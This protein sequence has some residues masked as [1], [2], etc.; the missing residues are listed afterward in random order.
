MPSLFGAGAYS[1]T[2]FGGSRY[3]AQLA[4][5]AEHKLH[6]YVSKLQEVELES[7]ATPAEFLA[8]RD[9]ARAITQVASA[10]TRGSPAAARSALAV[11]IQLDNAPLDGWLGDPGWNVVQAR[12]QANLTTLGIDPA[13][14]DRTLADMKSAA[15][16]A[17]V[18]Y[19]DYQSLIAA[20]DSYQDARD[21]VPNGYGSFPDPQT[22]YTQH[23]R[24]FFRGL[25]AGR[26]DAVAKLDSDVRTFEAQANAS[27][28]ETA[29]VNRDIKLLKNLGASVTNAQNAAFGDAIVAAFDNGSPTPADQA[30][31]HA[32][33]NA[34]FGPTQSVATH[35]QVDRL[36]ADTTTLYAALGASQAN[37]S[38]FVEDVKSVVENGADA[39]LNPFKVQVD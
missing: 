32:R 21:R 24:G 6:Q 3:G 28:A 31:L 29:V 5:Q 20:S 17:G 36:I 25:A 18:R 35:A 30:S 26:L 13:M 15:S 16:S 34:I 19:G 1:T 33:A 10:N 8:L 27:S 37:V 12:V 2:Q 38:T 22:Y 4:A 7:Q 9:D 39:S 23:L 11:T 14:I